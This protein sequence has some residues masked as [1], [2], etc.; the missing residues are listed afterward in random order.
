MPPEKRR[1]ENG[2]SRSA[3]PNGAH[4]L[5]YERAVVELIESCWNLPAF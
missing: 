1:N 3:R 5:I 4:G 2:T